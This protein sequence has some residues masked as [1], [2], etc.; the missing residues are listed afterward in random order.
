MLFL[1]QSPGVEH[2]EMRKEVPDFCGKNKGGEC[3]TGDEDEEDGKGDVVGPQVD[4]TLHVL[5]DDVPGSRCYRDVSISRAQV[6][7]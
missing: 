7:L 3:Q 4:G 1:T 2:L 6:L 5:P